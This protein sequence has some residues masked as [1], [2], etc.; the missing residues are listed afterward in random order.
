[1]LLSNHEVWQK[2]LTATSHVDYPEKAS[3]AVRPLGNNGLVR[4][5]RCY[6]ENS[7]SSTSE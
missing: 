3:D 7:D 5:L 1:M 4:S 2:N 6:Q